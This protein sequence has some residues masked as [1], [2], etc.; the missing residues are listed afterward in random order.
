M[1]SFIWVHTG[2]VCSQKVEIGPPIN[3]PLGTTRVAACND[4]ATTNEAARTSEEASCSAATGETELGGVDTT[5]ACNAVAAGRDVAPEGCSM[6]W[7]RAM[8][9][10]P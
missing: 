9:G 2:C 8:A 5:V 10:R 7:R 3:I 1:H 6:G 4:G